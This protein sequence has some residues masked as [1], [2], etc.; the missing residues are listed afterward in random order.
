MTPIQVGSSA[1]SSMGS[2]VGSSASSPAG[3]SENLL[4]ERLLFLLLCFN[5]CCYS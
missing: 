2:S 1:G 4:S 3:S 5:F